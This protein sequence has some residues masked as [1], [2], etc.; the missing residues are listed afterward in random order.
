VSAGSAAPEAAANWRSFSPAALPTDAAAYLAPSIIVLDN[1]SAADLSAPQLQRLGQYVRDLGGGLLILGGD[2]AFAAGAYAGTALESLSPL[3]ST[4]PEPVAHWVL[5]VDSSGSMNAPVGNPGGPGGTRWRAATEAAAALARSLPPNDL[6]SV[7]GFAADVTWWSRG[8]R[9]ADAGND[10][11]PPK[12]AGPSGPT[13]LRRA[14]AAVVAAADHEP[15]PPTQLV[16][17]T[18]GNAEIPNPEDLGQTMRSRNVRLHLLAIG[19]AGGALG[20]PALRKLVAD[21]GGTLVE[22]QNP[23]RWAAAARQLLRGAAPRLLHTAPVQVRFEG[24]LRSLP[25][26]EVAPWNRTWLKRDAS[27]LAEAQPTTG[28]RAPMAAN[29]SLGEG[30]VAA[31]AFGAPAVEELDALF[32]LVQRPPRDPRLSVAFDPGPRL[33]VAVDAVD[34]GN[35][36]NGLKIWLQLAD[37]AQP[38]V[39]S[40]RLQV[41]QVAPGRYELN[42][43]APRSPVLATVRVEGRVVARAAVAGRYAPEFEAIGN[44]RAAMRSLAERSGGTVVEPGAAAPLDLPRPRRELR[45]TSPLA[46]AGA[47][48]LA[49]ALLRWRLA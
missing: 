28:E 43:A 14:L 42:V 38:N 13:E 21:T 29:W 40:D 20:L 1:V 37:S 11:R 2:R 44:D 23:A 4:P 24:E 45:L 46:A 31:V 6:L 17:I 36:L 18:D 35:Y 22:E 48:C 16:L 39:L 41:P 32:R 30:S 26:R 33:R 3:A 12:G 27:S 8:R 10:A 15:A 34:D 25:S 19:E 47:A 5:L 9:A 49:L 7:A